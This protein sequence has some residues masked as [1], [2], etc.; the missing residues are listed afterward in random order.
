MV[1]AGMGVITNY[2][3]AVVPTWA[4][5]P[6]LVWPAFGVLIVAAVVL[7]F[8]AKSLDAGAG[9][10]NPR[11]L[12][13]E[14]VLP[15]RHGSL[16]PAHTGGP[17]RGR[18]ADLATMGT[19][20]RRPDGRFAVLCGTGGM[21]KTTLAALL[22]DQAVADGTPVFWVPWRD[23]RD[24]AEQM[25]RVALACGLS[26]E[27]L[28]SVR[29]GRASLPDVVWQ[30][31]A[32]ERSWLLVV[33]NV[34]Q[35]AAVGPDR[36]PVASYRGWIRPGGS[37]LLLVTSRDTD[38]DTWGGRAVLHRLAPLDPDAGARALLDGAPEA[39]TLEDARLLADRLGGLPLALHTAGRYLAAVASRHRTFTAYRQALDHELSALL[40]AEHPDAADP[41][42]ARSLVRHTWDLSLGQ[43]TARGTT[44]ARHILR[45]LSLFG[46]APVPLSLITPSLVTAATG[47]A[48]TA[49]D[50]EAAINGLHTYGLVDTP[51][52]GPAGSD[53]AQVSLHPLIREISALALTSESPDPSRWYRALAD[54]MVTTVRGLNGTGRTGWPIGRLL[55]PHALAF[56]ELEGCRDDLELASALYSLARLLDDAGEATEALRLDRQAATTRTR[57][58]GPDHP[59]TLTSIDGLA[60]TLQSLRQH[61]DAIELLEQNT[62][63]RA[64]VLGPDHPNTLR[65]RHNLANALGG[66]NRHAE[67]VD[68]HR[69]NLTDRARV[70]GPDH[71][72]ALESRSGLGRELGCL[73][74]YTEAFELFEVNLADRTR[75]LGPNH[76]DTLESL[77]DLANAL[78]SLGR[79]GEA[80]NLYARISLHRMQVLGPDHPD[81]LLSQSKL[82]LM[83]GLQGRHAEAIDRHRR[84]LT[85]C[86]RVLGP[87][88]PDTLSTRNNLANA[89]NHLGRHAEAVDLHRQ[90]LTDYTRVLGPNHPDTRSSRN[91]LGNALNE[92]GRHAEAAD[93]HRQNLTDYTRTLGAEHPLSLTSRTNLAMA[94]NHLG[95]HTEAVEQFRQVLDDRTRA[96]GTDH[97][98]TAR[99]RNNLA[100]AERHL[101]WSR[102]WYIR[103]WRRLGAS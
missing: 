36:E 41:D 50:V 23:E 39:G 94:L 21:G 24:L 7:Q 33:D 56:A 28:E 81:T 14:R 77:D 20:L 47:Q 71:P 62:I 35:P 34:D 6:R 70:L 102:R 82:A 9:R 60:V 31:L 100:V 16:A 76:P 63:D 12:P 57:V 61:A 58:L 44:R 45:L 15:N 54:H 66:L 86:T 49:T 53:I 17:V 75:V 37:G 27:Q 65:S 26:E 87:D 29:S 43:L 97:P 52:T 93:L 8:W 74:Q 69:Q 42:V 46:T 72:D 3:T 67:A 78:V 83:L 38:P 51:A 96:L 19:M 30:Q 92:R 1:A 90:N 13:L 5:D 91:N 89:L 32:L 68:L 95:R 99:S 4:Q 101:A 18:D 98:D 2:V 40:G 64:R 88:H 103:P 55:A 73:G 25:T 80:A 84:S 11:Q 79:H 85:D 59:D 48:T 22:A 10:A